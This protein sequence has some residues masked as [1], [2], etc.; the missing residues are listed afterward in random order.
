MAEQILNSLC[1]KS[2]ADC[3]EVS[4]TWQ[5]FISNERFYKNRIEE[6]IRFQKLCRLFNPN[7]RGKLTKTNIL[8]KISEQLYDLEQKEIE[9]IIDLCLELF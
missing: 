4:Q 3:R 8:L 6:E 5:E 2:L 1:N 9:E 7:K